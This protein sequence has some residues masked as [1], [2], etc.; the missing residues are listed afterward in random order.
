M[1]EEWQEIM[2][3]VY[4][5]P[6]LNKPFK[7][8]YKAME[9]EL[10]NIDNDVLKVHKHILCEGHA[11]LQEELKKVLD[12]GGEGLMLRDPMSRYENKRSKTLLKVKVMH[13]EEA[14]VVGHEEGTGRC[15]GLRGALICENH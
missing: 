7:D 10:S 6:G 9:E 12:K 11:H 1:E 4:D 15:Q 2:Y 3:F 14:T 13:D 8:R 5:C